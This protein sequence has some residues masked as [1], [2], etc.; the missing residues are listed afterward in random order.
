LRVVSVGLP[1]PLPAGEL[2]LQAR[3]PDGAIPS[4]VTVCVDV[5][6]GGKRV[7]QAWARAEMY[8]SRPVL[9]LTRDVR[10]GEVLAPEDL[11]VSAGDQPWNVLSDPAQAVGK[12]MKRSMRARAKLQA[13]DLEVVPVVDRGDTV[14]LVARVGGVVASIPGKALEAAGV[15]ETLRVENS[16]SGRPLSGVLRDG[17]V[18]DVTAGFGR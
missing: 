4:P 16:S 1:G 7:G 12:K 11:Q 18:V 13:R 5:L 3:V 14:R 9:T 10:R 17:G 6:A 8:R 2:E 15:G